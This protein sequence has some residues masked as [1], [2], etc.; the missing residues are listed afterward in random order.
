MRDLCQ[1]SLTQQRG[2]QCLPRYDDTHTISIST[3]NA[4]FPV[5]GFHHGAERISF[6]H[7]LDFTVRAPGT[8]NRAYCRN[9][10]ARRFN[11]R[12]R[13]SPASPKPPR[14][15]SRAVPN[16]KN[17]HPLGGII[18]PVVNNERPNHHRMY[19]IARFARPP[20]PPI[21]LRHR[22]Q[23]IHRIQNVLDEPGRTLRGVLY[24]E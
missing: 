18:N 20:R 13:H 14:L 12:P 9:S 21:P 2:F 15:P 23:I 8:R 24:P 17:E 5:C 6:D 11:L 3:A 7:C 1:T 22:V 4:A 19:R 16:L 10:P